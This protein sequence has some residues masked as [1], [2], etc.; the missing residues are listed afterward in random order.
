[1]Y[2]V[3]VRV[4]KWGFLLIL[5]LVIGGIG[6]EVMDHWIIPHMTASQTFRNWS[7]LK[8]AN[9]STTIINN[10]QQLV[11]QED[12]SIEKTSSQS[13]SSV[14]NV[15]S[16]EKKTAPNAA[17][18]LAKV[19]SA[20]HSL[21]A[22]GVILSNDGVVA[23]YRSA[24][25]EQNA[26][27]VVLL[28][29]GVT[30]PATLAGIDPLTNIAFLRIDMTGLPTIAFANSDDMRPGKKLIL[31]ANS[32]EEYRNRF[33]LSLLSNINKSFNLS[34]KTVASSE[35][36]EGTFEVDA[37]NMGSY[38]GGPAIDF[39]GELVGLVGSSRLDNQTSYFLL[40]ANVV[41]Q[42]FERFSQ[43]TLTERPVFGAYYTTIT[44]AYALS[45]H[46]SRDRGA[47]IDAP[48]VGDRPG[49]AV[50]AGSPAEKSG[51]KLGDIVIAVNKKEINLDYPLSNA[52]GSFSPG[53]AIDLLVI[54]DG[55]EIHVSAKL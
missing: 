45:H 43:G 42:S 23:T 27:Y 5:L 13:A 12:D 3:A 20:S 48:Q 17:S 46:L 44:T 54:R 29:N 16:I 21:T 15:I 9:E 41:R 19:V 31:M 18:V 37:L 25:I 32:T 26:E 51:L 7:F 55:R 1:M 35:K 8:K 28:P 11:I 2:T 49:A 52:I 53:N 38:L 14:V 4:L 6:S 40:P 50:L 24:L 47:L 39:G 22:S 30:Y 36:W 33:S 34:E 10:T